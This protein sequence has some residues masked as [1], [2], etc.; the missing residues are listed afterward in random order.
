MRVASS[1]NANCLFF[2]LPTF[3]HNES[4]N[5]FIIKIMMQKLKFQSEITV[6]R[7]GMKWKKNKISKRGKR[8]EMSSRA[9]VKV[10][11]LFPFRVIMNGFSLTF[12]FSSF[13]VQLYCRL[14]CASS[15]KCSLFSSSSRFFFALP[16]FERSFPLHCYSWCVGFGPVLNQS[17]KQ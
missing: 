11:F 5:N 3:R 13:S 9:R 6:F 1:S 17:N 4:R 10:L 12:K 16:V 14:F 15:L 8:L 7:R 2:F